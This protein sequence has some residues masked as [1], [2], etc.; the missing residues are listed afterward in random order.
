MCVWDFACEFL[1]PEK[2]V[3]STV[4]YLAEGVCKSVWSNLHALKVLPGY[5][6]HTLARTT[7][8]LLS[9]KMFSWTQ[10][11]TSVVVN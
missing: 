7:V 9:F 6:L 10:F 2:N 1:I 8:M 3:T 11:T 4:A 5:L